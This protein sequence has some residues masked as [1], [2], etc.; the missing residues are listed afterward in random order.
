MEKEL[1]WLVESSEAPSPALLQDN[2]APPKTTHRAYSSISMKYPQRGKAL[3][4][5]VD[6]CHTGRCYGGWRGAS[7]SEGFFPGVRKEHPVLIV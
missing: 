2:Y 5:Q 3:R 6:E 1:C 7:E 4:P